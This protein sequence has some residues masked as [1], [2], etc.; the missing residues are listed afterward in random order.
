MRSHFGGKVY[1]LALD[2][3]FTCPN[4][5]GTCGTGGC[6]FCS[7]GSGDFAIPVGN[8]VRGALE[9]AKL[10]VG[11]K[12]SSGKY[13]AYFQSF[14]GTYAPVEHL[15]ELYSAAAEC[16][17]V[18][19]LDIATRPD[20]LGDEVISLLK[21]LNERLPVWIELGLQTVH[22]STARYIRRGYPLEAYDSAVRALK[23]AGIY[24]IAHMI[25]GLPGE[26]RDMIYETASHIARSGADGIKLQ[27]LH[28]LRGTDLAADY[29]RGMFETLSP[30][31]Y[32]E[33]IEGC[34]RR[35]SPVMTVHRLTGDGARRD[36]IAP[37]WSLDK[38]HV[39]NKINA[40]LERDGVIQGELFL[41]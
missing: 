39:L 2:G 1:K 4:R 28:V 18:V 37:L 11:G 38:K 24:T 41:P 15:R 3:G 5:D 32:I 19:A 40:A 36:L 30:E 20:C 35:I 33:I 16:E 27:L 25:I 17:G 13:I 10:L 9:T 12:N 31:E 34:I 14:T 22:E 29:E 6:I 7:G 21:E 26:T 8:D 23:D